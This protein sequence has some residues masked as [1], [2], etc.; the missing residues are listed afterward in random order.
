MIFVETPISHF[1]LREHHTPV[2]GLVA[3]PTQR[4]LDCGFPQSALGPRAKQDSE[5]LCR[6][7]SN[8]YSFNGDPQQRKPPGCIYDGAMEMHVHLFVYIMTPS[9]YPLRCRY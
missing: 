7:A 8:S 2:F 1:V 6:R 3:P 9:S 4:N 5:L